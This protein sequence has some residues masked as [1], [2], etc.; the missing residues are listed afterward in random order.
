[1][2]IELDLQVKNPQSEEGWNHT[3][4][5]ILSVIRRSEKQYPTSRVLGFCS[6]KIIT[7]LPRDWMPW[8]KRI[9]LEWAST[10]LLPAQNT[11]QREPLG[12]H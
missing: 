9:S 11:E 8:G 1:M 5:F 2:I 4:K 3:A 6:N 12:K 7:S 10:I